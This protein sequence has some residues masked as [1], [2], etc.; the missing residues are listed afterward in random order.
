[1]SKF[2]RKV[3]ETTLLKPLQVNS[4]NCWSGSRQF[5]LIEKSLLKELLSY[6]RNQNALILLFT[7]MFRCQS[8]IESMLRSRFSLLKD[9]YRIMIR[10]PN[11]GFK[12]LNKF[13][14]LES[15]VMVS[16]KSSWDLRTIFMRTN[17]SLT[18]VEALK[19][20]RRG[21]LRIV[22]FFWQVVKLNDRWFE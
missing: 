14:S 9:R 5:W 2:Q 19:E 12:I 6:E 17:V 10:W 4:W 22:I 20:K 11:K 15:A 21:K 1:M 7:K 18:C 16:A 3:F 8:E 13:E